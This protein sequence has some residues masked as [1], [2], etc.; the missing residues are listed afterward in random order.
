MID[1]PRLQREEIWQKDIIRQHA[2]LLEE[3]CARFFS[4]QG[5]PVADG[6]AAWVP[7][8]FCGGDRFRSLFTQKAYRWERC[9]SCG[10]LQKRPRPH[11]DAMARFYSQGQAVPF[12]EARVLRAQ[13]EVRTQKIFAPNLERLAGLL[14]QTGLAGDALLDIGC[15]NGLF[16]AAAR[17]R[18]LFARYEGVEA[19]APSAAEARKL[20]FQ[21]YQGMFEDVAIPCGSY[22]VITCFAMFQFI[23]EPMAFLKKCRTILRPGGVLIFTSSNG[24]SP[25][26]LLLRGSSPVLP[27]HMLQLPDPDHFASLCAGAGFSQV[28]VEATGQLDVQIIRE[29]WADSPPDLADPMTEFLYRLVVAQHT[30]ELADALQTLLKKANLSGH[31]W[32]QA[33]TF[34]SP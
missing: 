31:L 9:L 22:D 14:A 4:S 33:R 24:W 8:V 32:M 15:A 20:G 13:K 19:N 3:D 28:S 17:E 1:Q 30:P 27:G 29:T 6:V 21:I 5:D 23:H 2:A 18:G 25:D 26:I 7:C 16:L 12:F 11:R 34:S 10:L